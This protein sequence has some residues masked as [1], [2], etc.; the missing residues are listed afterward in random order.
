M[1]DIIL[2]TTT[3]N[4][5]LHL[6]QL[7]N[8]FAVLSAQ[9]FYLEKTKCTFFAKQVCFCGHLLTNGTRRAAPHKL[10][11]VK[12]WPTPTSLRLL[13]RFL[14][15]AQYYSPYMANYAQLATPLTEGT[16][17]SECST[18][19]WTP[20]MRNAFEK[21]KAALLN[22]AVLHI[23]R[24]NTPFYIQVDASKT[25]TWLSWTHW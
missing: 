5:V 17:T 24:Y 14:G 21:V 22:Q 8:L 11:V 6:Q 12:N 9:K 13:R 16:R 2:S 3:D 23:I 19:R 20:E 4:F 7:D 18:F 15:F 1:D 25:A 10:A